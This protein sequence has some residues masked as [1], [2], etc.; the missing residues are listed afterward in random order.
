MFNRGVKEK[1]LVGKSE[2]SLRI[3]SMATVAKATVE[4][5]NSQ[6]LL[7]P[8]WICRHDTKLVETPGSYAC[9]AR[10]SCPFKKIGFGTGLCGK[11]VPACTLIRDRKSTRLN[12][13]HYGLS[14]MP[15]SA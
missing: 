13:S 3:Y 10:C 12:S 6:V 2:P 11:G 4:S 15:S 1:Q 7:P 5:S 9:S 8:V 14:R